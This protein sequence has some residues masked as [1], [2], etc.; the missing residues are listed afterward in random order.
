MFIGKFLI[1]LSK[2]TILKLW[3]LRNFQNLAKIFRKF[4]EKQNNSEFF[5]LGGGSVGGPS[6]KRS[7][8]IINSCWVLCMFVVCH[9]GDRCV[10]AR[11]W[12]TQQIDSSF[13]CFRQT[14][15][16]MPHCIQLLISKIGY[17]LHH[18]FKCH[19]KLSGVLCNLI[20]VSL[21]N[22]HFSHMYVYFFMP[23]SKMWYA[24]SRI[25]WPR[26]ISLKIILSHQ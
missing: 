13:L 20:L 18:S 1:I 2:T 26:W 12:K 14:S 15:H 8:N 19:S 24:F 3:N 16:I 9:C 25:P 6:E 17:C 11:H 21:C 10:A 4:L 23:L 5:I 22:Y 7:P